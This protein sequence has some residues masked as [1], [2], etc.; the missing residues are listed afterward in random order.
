MGRAATGG[1]ESYCALSEH[2]H[3]GTFFL[4]KFSKTK[5][6]LTNIFLVAWI[7]D[8]LEFSVSRTNNSFT[9]L[10]CQNTSLNFKDQ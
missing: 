9:V 4:K 1:W 8:N 10:V 3:T 6:F 5:H 7:L 2:I